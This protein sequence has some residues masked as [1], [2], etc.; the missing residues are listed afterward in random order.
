MSFRALHVGDLH[1]WSLP[2]SPV[3]L[4]SKRLLGV[5][6]LVLKRRRQFRQERAPDLVAGL[7]GRGADWALFSGDFTTT[8]LEPEFKSAGAA[9][10]PLLSALPHRVCAVPGNHDRYVAG[11]LADG[12]YDAHF[13]G[14]RPGTGGDWPCAGFLGDGV[15]LAGIDAVTWPGYLGSHGRV[16]A[17]AIDALDAWWRGARDTVRELWVLCHF[18][19]EEPR[20]L[21]PHDRGPQLH[22]APRLLEW[23][24]GVDRPVLFLH[25][26]HHRRWVYR[27]PTL[28]HLVYL[29]AG[30][31]LMR[32]RGRQPDLGFLELCH[33]PGPGTR[34]VLHTADVGTMQWSRGPVTIPA[35]AGAFT[36]LQVP[37]HS[38]DPAVRG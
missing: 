8:S 30:A 24:A 18:P 5:A 27:S 16:P 9:L 36:D 2:H 22:D 33:E 19:A 38:L 35:G 12:R 23:L 3:Q 25:G 29:N 37:A 28:P 1:F 15:A 20:E 26:H 14:L 21:L 17:H 34:V 31:P 11:E 6:N 13:G 4:L 7:L 32:Y 10:G